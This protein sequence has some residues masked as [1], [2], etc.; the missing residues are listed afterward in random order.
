[1]VSSIAFDHCVIHVSDWERSN[2]FYRDVL[3]AEIIPRGRGYAYRF[4]NVQLNCHGPGQV[5]QPLARLPVQPGNSDLCFAWPSGIDEARAHLRAHNVEIEFGPVER[6][7]AQGLGESL[8]FRDPD[9]SLLEFIC[10]E[11]S[12]QS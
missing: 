1:M 3:G 8:Y 6:A 9:G 4:G 11:N 5:G 2:A 12:R 7:G 10:Y